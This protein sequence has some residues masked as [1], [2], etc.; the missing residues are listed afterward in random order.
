M[1]KRLSNFLNMKD[2]RY[3]IPAADIYAFFIHFN[4]AR[5]IPYSINKILTLL[6]KGQYEKEITRAQNF[7]L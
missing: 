7:N 4:K 2:Y 1:A 6:F 5:I 3:M